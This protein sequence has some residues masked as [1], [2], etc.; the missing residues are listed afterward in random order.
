MAIL[1]RHADRR[2]GFTWASGAQ[3][4]ARW[5]DD[6]DGPVQ[7]LA[8]TPEGAWAEFLRHE[9]ITDPYEL[10][11]VTRR[12]WAIEVPD[13]LVENA[14]AVP[15]SKRVATGDPG[16]YPACRAAAAAQVAAGT[17][18]LK[19]PSSA[20]DEERGHLSVDGALN[21]GSARPAFNYVVFE[22]GQGWVG[23]MCHDTGAPDPDLLDRVRPL[24]P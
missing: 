14:V 7:Y 3:P 2:Y 23:W 20:L 6:G 22:P 4:A 5:H 18:V 21:V 17:T 12:V 1:F 8:S 9:E 10:D 24:H 11:G 19:A 13:E 15:V 16:T